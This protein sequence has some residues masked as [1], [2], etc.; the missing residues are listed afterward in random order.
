MRPYRTVFNREAL[1][2]VV[3]VDDA[4]FLEIEFWVNRIERARLRAETT[5]SWT[6]TAANCRWSCWAPQWSLTGRMT[7]CGKCGWCGSNRSET[8]R[9][10]GTELHALPEAALD[11]T[12]QAAVAQDLELLAFCWPAEC[13]GCAGCRGGAFGPASVMGNQKEFARRA[14]SG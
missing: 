4:A 9:G 12:Q 10:R 11:L 13:P 2:F 14:V 7:R 5:P 1:E 3:Q 6:T 8:A